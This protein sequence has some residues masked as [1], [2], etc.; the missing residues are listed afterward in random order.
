MAVFKLNRSS[1][2]NPGGWAVWRV[3]EGDAWDL[4]VTRAALSQ[5]D[6]SHL[7]ISDS[8]KSRRLL[9]TSGRCRN[10]YSRWEV[11]AVPSVSDV[12]TGNVV[13]G[14][15]VNGYDRLVGRGIQTNL[16]DLTTHI[17][18]KPSLAVTLIAVHLTPSA[19]AKG[20]RMISGEQAGLGGGFLV[21]V[22]LNDVAV[23]GLTKNDVCLA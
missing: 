23:V 9:A 20:D 2:S 7:S 1:G 13:A 4:G 5:V 12:N 15:G 10:G 16:P 22:E 11:V 21:T 14:T 18:D 19:L 17:P 8:C 3:C 6:G